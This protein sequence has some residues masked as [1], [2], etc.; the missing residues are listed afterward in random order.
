MKLYSKLEHPNIMKYILHFIDDM[1]AIVTVAEYKEAITL[2]EFVENYQ[3]NNQNKLIPPEDVLKIFG[4][5]IGSLNALYE[6]FKVC[7]RDLKP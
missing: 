2:E 4:R 3:Q 6:T 1:G 7:H 5:I